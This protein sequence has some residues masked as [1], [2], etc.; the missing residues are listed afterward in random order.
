MLCFFSSKTTHW[1]FRNDP[2]ELVTIFCCHASILFPYKHAIRTLDL[3]SLKIYQVE[4]GPKSSGFVIL[5][6]Y[7]LKELNNFMNV[8]YF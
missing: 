1:R 3:F 4:N 8:Y 2:R 7:V 5:W 6:K